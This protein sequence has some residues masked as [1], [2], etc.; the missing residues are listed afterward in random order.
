METLI[1]SVGILAIIMGLMTR[2]FAIGG[3]VGVGAFLLYFGLY[4]NGSWLSLIF[5]ALGT[6]LIIAEIFLPTYGILGLVGLALGAWGL[7]GQT[8]NIGEAL[9]DL[10]IG[11]IVGI[12]AF[13]ILVKL[14]YRVP[15][16][17]AIV[18]ESSLNK[19][20]GFQSQVADNSVFL[21]QEATTITPLRPTGKAEFSD[22][23]IHEVVSDSEIIGANERV[24]VVRVRN[25]QLL[26]RRV[27]HGE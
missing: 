20:R 14:G 12:V 24:K 8:P 21:N 27:E 1:F 3:V 7:M 25:N 9:V 11:V 15:F 10:V 4:D 22:H 19:S 17:N 23:N 2:R 18:L 5:F 6:V 26:V 13:Y 16:N